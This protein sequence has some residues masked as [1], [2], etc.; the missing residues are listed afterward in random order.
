M[1]PYPQAKLLGRVENLDEL[2]AESDAQIVLSTEATGLRTRV[3]ESFVQGLPVLTCPQAVRGIPG[4][5]PGHN[6]LMGNTGAEIAAHLEQTLE[7]PARLTA[8][9]EAAYETYRTLHSRS[10]VARQLEALLV[11]YFPA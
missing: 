6:I 8:I 3:I 4:L 9:A 2:Y 7:N 10:T 5:Q 11:R 1:E